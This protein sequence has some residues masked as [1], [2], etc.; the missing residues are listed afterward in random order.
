MYKTNLY[1]MH[2]F[3]SLYQI[4]IS[5]FI[6]A[7]I[8]KIYNKRKKYINIKTP[9]FPNHNTIPLLVVENPPLIT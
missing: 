7:T 9:T 4:K 3:I 8:Y 2:I 5:L 1:Y 6:Y